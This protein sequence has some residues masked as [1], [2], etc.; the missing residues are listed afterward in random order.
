MIKCKHCTKTICYLYF[1]NE[2]TAHSARVIAEITGLKYI[3]ILLVLNRLT[4]KEYD[5]WK[6]Q[7]DNKIKI[8]NTNISF[9][10]RG[11]E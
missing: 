1:N 10:K 8:V 5:F 7:D 9:V 6:E 4:K 2:G 11:R 3:D